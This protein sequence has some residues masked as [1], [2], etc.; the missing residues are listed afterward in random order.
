MTTDDKITNRK[1]TWEASCNTYANDNIL[2]DFRDPDVADE[3]AGQYE[4]SADGY[5]NHATD[6]ATHFT[7]NNSN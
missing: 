4:K 7:T 5:R 6:Y 2:D 3:A 1:S